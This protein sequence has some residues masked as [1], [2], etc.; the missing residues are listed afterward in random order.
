ME[1]QPS[2]E[3]QKSL[4]KKLCIFFT[5]IYGIQGLSQSGI[6][7]L[8]YLP[9]SFMLKEKMHFGPEQLSYFQGLVMVPWAIKPLYGLLSD[10]VPILGYR[11][12]SYF[13]LAAGLVTFSALY[14]ASLT[15]YAYDQLLF[16]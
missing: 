13:M 5:V 10:F 14:L 6:S 11:R 8:F 12:R 3:E 16:F 2:A 1:L 7:G 15:N 9:I 4:I